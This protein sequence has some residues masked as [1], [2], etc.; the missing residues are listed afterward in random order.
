MKNFSMKKLVLGIF[1]VSCMSVIFVGVRQAFAAGAGS[2]VSTTGAAV[3][4]SDTTYVAYVSLSGTLTKTGD[5]VKVYISTINNSWSM[6]TYYLATGALPAAGMTGYTWPLTITVGTGFAN[7]TWSYLY[8]H[9]FLT[10]STG[11]NTWYVAT[12]LNF[13]PSVAVIYTDVIWPIVTA[14]WIV[15][16]M[17]TVTVTNMTAFT[18]LYF[19]KP[20]FGKITFPGA[21]DLTDSNVQTF[22][23]GLSGYITMSNWFVQFTPT[24]NGANLNTTAQISMYITGTMPFSG[25][26]NAS[27]F[28]VKDGSGNVTGGFISSIVCTAGTPQGTCT[29]TTSH[30]TD[31]TLRPYLTDVHIQSNNATNTAY[32]KSGNV[33]TLWFTGSDTL[34]TSWMVVTINGSAA[35]VTITGA[36]RVWTATKTVGI[37]WDGAVSFTI[38]FYN[39]SG[40]VGG[41]SGTT[42]TATTDSS[43]MTIDNTNP[44][45]T[46]TS[47]TASRTGATTTVSGTGTETNI[48]TL[49]VNQSTT[50]FAWG[51][52]ST[53]VALA[54]WANTIVVTGTDLAWNV[55]VTTGSITRLTYISSSI[56]TI[57]SGDAMRFSFITDLIS[58][59]FV[60]YGT[61]GLNTIANSV[62]TWPTQAHIITLSS[63]IAET[64]YLYR[65]YA[66]NSALTGTRTDTGSFT[67]HTTSTASTAGDTTTSWA[68]SLIWATNAWFTFASTGTLTVSGGTNA[69]IISTSGFIIEAE[70]GTWNG[71][72]LP[73][74]TSITWAVLGTSIL[75]A[76]STNNGSTTTTRTVLT[77]IHVGSDTDNLIA[78]GA[79]TTYFTVSFVI[80]GGVAG[81]VIKLYRSEDASTWAANT[82]DATCTLDAN[83][84]CSF[85]TDHLS[86]FASV[87]ETTSAN[88][89]GW[90]GWSVS[91]VDY[92]PSGDT[93]ASYYDGLCSTTT[94]VVTNTTNTWAL[95]V[96]ATYSKE[97]N[98][99][100]T[101][102]YGLGITTQTSIAKADMNGTLIR[103][104]MAKMMVNYATKVMNLTPDTSLAC[105]F[106]DISS[107]NEE[108]QGYIKEACQLWLMGINDNGTPATSFDPNGEVTRAQFGT[109]L[110]RA[111]YGNEYNGGT[112]YYTNHLNALKTA[113]IMTKIDTPNTAEIRGFV[114]LMMMRADKE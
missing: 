82:P 109:V 87:K 73:P 16:N 46:I 25:A 12:T 62:Y 56:P 24:W 74:T 10:S 6:W 36:A 88:P 50:S 96:D 79:G 39:A 33:I 89:S 61:T 20:W 76:S 100:Y 58:T 98:D 5:I 23:Q 60:A 53:G 51:V 3:S 15:N 99:A 35:G 112:L 72:L 17:N 59:W 26:G 30:F 11:L 91:S 97:L 18:G 90:A 67:I 104:H 92:C 37:G 31:F 40:V 93:S 102:A 108:L 94:P 1:L 2:A 80:A 78:S 45:F 8:L 65:I 81:D 111:L 19:E 14:E 66:K 85:H 95:L 101:Y 106:T 105:N 7:Y 64:N 27:S 84:V 49:V 42:V 113:G 32:A 47:S 4:Y 57:L 34:S 48:S 29:F 63:L 70:N 77:T 28:V 44:T 43:A 107:Q 54:G 103:A 22:L 86:Y 110:S 13:V 83:K 9:T 69:L 38:D 68:T 114:M 71:E 21:L 41:I 55:W 75:P 52:W